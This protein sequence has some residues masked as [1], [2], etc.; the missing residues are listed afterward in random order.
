MAPLPPVMRGTIS[1]R[2]HGGQDIPGLQPPKYC[3]ILHLIH[4]GN[5]GSRLSSSSVWPNVSSS[6]NKIYSEP[7]ASHFHPVNERKL[8][9][10]SIHPE[11]ILVEACTV[12]SNMFQ[13]SYF[14]KRCSHMH[15]LC[16]YDVRIVRTKDPF[17]CEK[18]IKGV[19]CRW[20]LFNGHWSSMI[21]SL[22]GDDVLW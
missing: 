1:R 9:K 7:P 11:S 22:Y 21:S 16:D 19:S 5:V 3:S 2:P 13:N 17:S 10:W 18:F 14:H 15:T 12:K 8:S 4:Y 6:R 20:G